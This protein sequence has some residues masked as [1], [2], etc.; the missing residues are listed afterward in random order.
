MSV[1][2]I[3]NSFSAAPSRL[4]SAAYMIGP[5]ILAPGPMATANGGL[6]A[7]LNN[8]IRVVEFNLS[9]GISIS[10]CC[11]HCATAGVG[12]AVSFGIYSFDGSNLLVNSGLFNA[13]VN[14]TDFENTFTS[15]S[16]P[17]GT[18]W[19]AQTEG[20]GVASTW[21]NLTTF[22]GFLRT[23]TIF[24]KMGRSATASVGGVLPA[25]ISLVLT[26]DADATIIEAIWRP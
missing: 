20:A 8:A 12:A 3:I 2:N 19:H 23:N 24:K 4:G 11:A 13:L 10:R 15:V 18:Y 25:A 1:N 16:L 9:V 22:P 6:V 26:D 17:P 5:G 7:G 14:N 21:T